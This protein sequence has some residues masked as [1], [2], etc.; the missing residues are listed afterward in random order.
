MDV[1]V[2]PYKPLDVITKEPVD[3]GQYVIHVDGKLAGFVGYHNGA[4][5]LMHR[6]FSPLELREIESA[7]RRKLTP[8]KIGS[9]LQPGIVQIPKPTETNFGDFD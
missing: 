5:P 1:V 4:R 7:V 9:I 6:R 3:G 8:Q 2:K